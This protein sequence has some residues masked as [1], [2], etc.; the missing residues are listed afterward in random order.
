MAGEN[1][2]QTLRKSIAAQQ[3]APPAQQPPHH[4][5]Q[6]QHPRPPPPPPPGNPAAPQSRGE[7]VALKKE[8]GL[9]SACAII[10]GGPGGGWMPCRAAWGVGWGTPDF[11][12]CGGLRFELVGSPITWRGVGGAGR[13]ARA[14]IGEP[15]CAGS[16]AECSR[17]PEF[18][19][20]RALNRLPA[21]STDG[22]TVTM[23]S[24]QPLAALR[25][26]VPDAVW[27]RPLR[28]APPKSQA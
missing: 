10:I 5:Q 9:V 25:L 22:W 28:C 15:R 11:R 18:P 20:K 26:C 19:S 21:V 17:T 23:L 3:P 6:Q 8:I 13:E 14:G 12:P 4:P 27:K 2:H 16:K 7:R 24:T 1:Q